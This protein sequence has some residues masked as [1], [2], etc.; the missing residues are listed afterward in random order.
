MGRKSNGNGDLAARLLRIAE[1]AGEDA[2]WR[3]LALSLGDNKGKGIVERMEAFLHVAKAMREAGVLEEIE[4]LYAVSHPIIVIAEARIYSRDKTSPALD[5]VFR[6]LD[7]VRE[8]HG[9]SEDEY[10][11]SGEGPEEFERLNNEYDRMIDEIIVATFGEY[12]EP[13]LGTMYRHDRQRFY[14]LREKGRQRFFKSRTSS[15]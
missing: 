1:E 9:L 14:H 12:G 7:A 10:W 5:A 15:N 13:E 3:E 2:D 8:K 4:A 11:P 6:K